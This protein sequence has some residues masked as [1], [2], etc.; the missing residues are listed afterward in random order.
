MLPTRLSVLLR[1]PRG[2]AQ[3]CAHSPR[4]A[5]S[6]APPP[7]WGI[8]SD[9]VASRA[10]RRDPP[11][12]TCRDEET[13]RAARPPAAV[14]RFIRA[15]ARD[16]G[17]GPAAQGRER[18]SHPDP[19]PERSSHPRPQAPPPTWG[20]PPPERARTLAEAAGSSRRAG[21]VT[22]RRPGCSAR[23]IMGVPPQATT[24]RGRTTAPRTPR[25]GGGACGVPCRL[26][27][28]RVAP[29]IADPRRDKTHWE[30]HGT[31]D[32]LLFPALPSPLL[33]PSPA[34]N[35]TPATTE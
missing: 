14:R 27:W 23:C 32:R 8:S 11:A 33:A 10:R 31:A 7:R 5:R 16:A 35:Y 19:C 2:P 17:C 30:N 22:A 21:H 9:T 25:G 6:P 1:L 15:E 20:A 12:A 4:R 18:S 13:L 29:E 24:P 28:P 3:R 34:C 26:G